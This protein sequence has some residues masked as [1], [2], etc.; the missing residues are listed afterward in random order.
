MDLTQFLDDVTGCAAEDL[1]D[2]YVRRSKPKEDL[3]T[4]TKHAWDMVE[5]A[6]REDRK[7]RAVWWEQRSASKSYVRRDELEAAMKAVLDGD[8]K[9]LYVRKLDR[10]DRRGMGTV[11]SMLDELDTR[12]A[13]LRVV[14]EGLDSSVPGQRI[15]FAVLAER[16]RDEAHDIAWRT[17]EGKD[18]HK[19]LGEWQ[20]GVVPYGLER[21]EEKGRLQLRADEYPIAREKIA[22]PLMEGV[23]ARSVAHQL[24]AEGIKTR[25]GAMW[26]ATTVAKLAHSPLWAGLLPDRE[27]ML[28]E[29]GNP[30]G[31]W[32]HHG[33]PYLDANG[34]TISVGQGVITTGE[35]ARIEAQL[36]SRTRPDGRGKRP[37]EYLITDTLRCG[38]CKGPM[39]GGGQAAR[40]GRYHCRTWSRQGKAICQGVITLRR[41]VE[42]TVMAMWWSHVSA[43]EPGD[44]ALDEIARRWVS[45][46]DPEKDAR[47]KEITAELDAVTARMAKLDH[48]HYVRGRLSEERYDELSAQQEAIR[49]SLETE[50][51][52]LARES[53]LTL[54]LADPEALKEA[55]DASSLTERRALI[56]CALRRVTIAPAKGQGDKTPMLERLTPEWVDGPSKVTAAESVEGLVEPVMV[57]VEGSKVTGEDLA[58]AA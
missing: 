21:A 36:A 8:S 50:G 1:A 24:N 40:G 51:T 41:R 14:K 12:R 22:V 30:T 31:R 20:G 6:H 45:L 44:T 32:K 39:E 54:L 18:A 49:A 27:R 2:I 19:A 3:A 25:N 26:T 5:A 33:R 17:Q 47:R 29:H 42:E 23:S 37:P 34:R 46:Q 48:D 57:P 11:G 28:D 7:I 10:F 43:L 16:A 13:R 15:I 52:E 56:R 9:T 38:R 53:D 55:W 4:L 35:R 58:P